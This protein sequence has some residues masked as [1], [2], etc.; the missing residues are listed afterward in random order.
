MQCPPQARP[1]LELHEAVGLGRRG[2]DDLPDVEPEA[3]AHQRNLV[4]EPDV[5]RAE[6]ILE[7][8]HHLGAL[9]RADQNDFVEDVL[10]NLRSQ[11]SAERRSAA[12]DLRDVS[13]RKLLVRRV[14]ALGRE[15]DR[16]VDSDREPA[17]LEHRHEQLLSG[18]RIGGTAEDHELSGVDPLADLFE[19]RGDMRNVGVLGLRERCRHADVDDVARRECGEIHGRGELAVRAGQGDVFGGYV[20]DVRGASLDCRH[21]ARIE[22]EARDV[23]ARAC[24]LDRQRQSDIAEA[25]DPD[26]CFAGFDAP[27][28]FFEPIHGW[29][30]PEDSIELRPRK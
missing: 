29:L 16:E 12:D 26:T 23:E 17:G 18:S 11:L 6:G 19:R 10:V 9:S 4:R 15:R 8:L 7:Q 1:R 27:A 3:V 14:D 20:L 5:D 13:H 30:L 25:D 28:Q 21:L 24:E 2:V 22:V